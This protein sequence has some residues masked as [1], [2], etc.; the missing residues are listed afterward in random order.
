M[1]EASDATKLRR[2][3]YQLNVALSTLRAVR[4]E[5]GQR[6]QWGQT[7]SNLCFNLAQNDSYDAAHRQSMRDCQENWDKIKTE[8]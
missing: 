3:K 7:M 2:V 5:L 4:V 8:C 6:R 1:R